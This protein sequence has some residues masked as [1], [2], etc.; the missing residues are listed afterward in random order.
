MSGKLFYN[1]R[2]D[3]KMFIVEIVSKRLRRSMNLGAVLDVDHWAQWKA[4]DLFI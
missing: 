3:G 4:S 2:M 1:G